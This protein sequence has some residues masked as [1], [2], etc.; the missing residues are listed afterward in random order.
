MSAIDFEVCTIAEAC[1][2]L[3]CS[4]ST[5][6]RARKNNLL[7]FFTINRAVRF[8]VSDILRLRRVIPMR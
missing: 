5:I 6:Y 4:R 8:N 1:E 3:R 2:L 7:P